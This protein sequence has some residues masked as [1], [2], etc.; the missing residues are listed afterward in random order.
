MPNYQFQCTKCKHTF[1][2]KLHIDERKGPECEPCTECG[3]VKSVLQMLGAT[4]FGDPVRLGITRPSDG[5]KD[6]LRKIHDANHGST[7]KDNSRYL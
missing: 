7:I 1:E 3:A 5:F 4:P 2:K 6:V